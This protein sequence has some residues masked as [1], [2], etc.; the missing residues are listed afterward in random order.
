M[1]NTLCLCFGDLHFGKNTKSYN[2]DIAA[3]RLAA[4]VPK[5][6]AHPRVKYDPPKQIRVLLLGDMVE[7]SGI[8]PSQDAVMGG[9]ATEQVD[10]CYVA[11]ESLIMDLL[12][13]NL[14]C[15]IIIDAVPGNHGRQSK[16]AHPESNWDLVLYSML[17]SRFG[18]EKRVVTACNRNK[19]CVVENVAG[20]SGLI[21]HI[22]IP[23]V[24]TPN[25]QRRFLAWILEHKVDWI[26][27]GHWHHIGADTECGLWHLRNGSLCGVDDFA[28]ERGLFS[29]PAQLIFWANP[30]VGIQG[31]DAISW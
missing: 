19:F 26:L 24:G 15:E 3:E 27:N 8:Y 14:K 4:Y 1:S 28:E 17:A 30:G 22:G 18:R 23:H 21:T 6:Q 10:A 25:R 9:N 20:T 31:I 5:L 12:R 29:R 13:A 11:L 2:L 16:S 7:G